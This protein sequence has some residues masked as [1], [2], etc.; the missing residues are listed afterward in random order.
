M[1]DEKIV[2][3]LDLRDSVAKADQ[4][5]DGLKDVR[6]EAV[7]VGDVYE[8]LGK[9]AQRAGESTEH[10]R[11]STANFGR[12]SLET[13][14]IIQDFAQGGIGGIINNIEGFAMAIGGGAGLAG[15]LT[16]LGV[17]FLMLKEPIKDFVS[18]LT[19]GAE[20]IPDTRS[21]IE[22][23]NE[24][25]ATAKGRLD[26]MK[27]AWNG[28]TKEAE[29]YKETQAEIIALEARAAEAK[30]VEAQR[31]KEAAAAA[32]VNKP[33]VEAASAA[34]AAFGGIDKF[35]ASIEAS[36]ST[37]AADD[38]RAKLDAKIKERD[39]AVAKAKLAAG[40]D[41][42]AQYEA[43]ELGKSFDWQIKALEGLVKDADQK[44]R[45]DAAALTTKFLSGD[46][47]A[48]KQLDKGM[49]GRGFDIGATVEQQRAEELAALQKQ[50]D[51]RQKAEDDA[52]EVARQRK[53]EAQAKE[54]E[55][56]EKA[57]QEGKARDEA[58]FAKA[59]EAAAAEAEKAKEAEARDAARAEKDAA[60]A[61]EAARLADVQRRIDVDTGGGLTD[62]QLED[63]AKQTLQL[64]DRGFA[65]LESAQYAI[66]E[67]IRNQEEMAN[68]LQQ[69]DGR[70]RQ[71]GERAGRVR[72][73]L[74]FG[75]L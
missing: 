59:N 4:L 41:T 42:Y 12:T 64:M 58:E 17:G 50:I 21:A 49:P 68:R 8:Q 29:E 67:V 62:V 63:A 22:K 45:D 56:D 11:K 13:G 24:S 43:R 33:Y 6:K 10:A 37:F 54:A 65:P 75:D 71:Q 47:G 40:N 30:L 72:S 3:G 27:E 52:A 15:A 61:A 51:A 14:R 26:A 66:A 60:K 16:V 39:E 55:D 9:Q 69:M 2:L 1:A 28:T 38:A 36:Q 57:F 46:V 25:L 73:I 19:K 74:D 48:G 18:S 23:L 31:K 32:D 7:Q 53:K 20:E 5:A 44:R 70:W 34:V 35:G